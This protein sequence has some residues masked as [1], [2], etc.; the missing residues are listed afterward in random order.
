MGKSSSMA[1]LASDWVEGSAESK[2]SQFAFTF[3][4]SLC[5]VNDNSMLQQIIIKQHG[6]KGKN[7]PES[8]IRSILD[9]EFGKVLL[10][11]DGY[12]EYAKGTNDDLDTAIE[13]TIGECF[14]ILTSRDGDYI[15]KDILDKMDGEI[16]ITGLSDENIIKCASKYLESDKLAKDLI[17]KSK[18]A[19]IYDLLHIPIVLLMVVF[20]Y[21]KTKQLPKSQ[22]EIVKSIVFMCIDRSSM[23][24][25]GKKAKDIE[26][27]EDMLKRLGKLSLEALKQGKLLILRVRH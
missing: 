9:G 5:H 12:D 27:L 25:F 4:I 24:H 17:E 26:G 23:K 21:Y 3:L 14:L 15:S 16:E 2:L 13:D 20:L 1:I 7:I 18:N 6:L 10:L 22:T 11:I 8:Q 19:D